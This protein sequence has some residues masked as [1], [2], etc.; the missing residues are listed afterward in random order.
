MMNSNNIKSN[1]EIIVRKL[2]TCP[3]QCP[4]LSLTILV[5]LTLLV[6]ALEPGSMIATIAYFVYMG[7]VLV[8]FEKIVSSFE[9]KKN[10]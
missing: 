5:Q 1:I 4:I 6:F 10:K 8:L 2:R 3:N 9:N 7:T